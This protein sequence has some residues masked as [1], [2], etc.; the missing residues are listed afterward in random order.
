MAAAAALLAVG[1]AAGHPAGIVPVAA[2]FGIL[3]L[4]TV[5][6]E[7]RLQQAIRGP[8]RATVLS[9]AGLGSEVMALA[10]FAG[11]GFGESTL[12]IPVL[13]ALVALPLAGG[14]LLT[15]RWLPPAGQ[16][17]DGGQAPAG[18]ATPSPWK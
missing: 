11:F 9:V 1:S 16:S 4:F 13:M 15:R 8:A 10:M 14:A 5:L 3:E 2:C 18:P 17:T 6:G 7:A 12:G